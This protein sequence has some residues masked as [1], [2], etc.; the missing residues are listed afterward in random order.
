[1]KADDTKD[2]AA[3]GISKIH[4]SLRLHLVTETNQKSIEIKH[5]KKKHAKL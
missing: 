4:S 3:L 2:T 1:M 5:R